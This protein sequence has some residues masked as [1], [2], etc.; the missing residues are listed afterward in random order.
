MRRSCPPPV[1]ENE[2]GEGMKI[3]AKLEAITDEFNDLIRDMYSLVEEIGELE[4]EN[5]EQADEIYDLKKE[6]EELEKEN[7][8]LKE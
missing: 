8:A 1:E 7:D 6:V 3:S 4:S 2:G 5:N